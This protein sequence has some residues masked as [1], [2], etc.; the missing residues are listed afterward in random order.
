[1]SSKL[2]YQSQ[3]PEMRVPV[4]TEPPFFEWSP[5]LRADCHLNDHLSWAFNSGKACLTEEG[6]NQPDRH[7]EDGHRHERSVSAH[8]C[9]HGR[10]FWGIQ[11]QPLD[12]P[13]QLQHRADP[14]AQHGDRLWTCVQTGDLCREHARE[15]QTAGGILRLAGD[16][17]TLASQYHHSNSIIT[18]LSSHYHHV[19]I[20]L[21]S[22]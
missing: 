16:R 17:T 3:N 7:V 10:G 5:C 14:H 8:A 4:V 13:L 21:A 22:H 2:K 6:A 12:R 9:V 18:S 19:V 15:L 1:M 20:T 11:L